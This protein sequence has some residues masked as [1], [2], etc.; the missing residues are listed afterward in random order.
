[1]GSNDLSGVIGRILKDIRIDLSDEFDKNFEREA[2]FSQAWARRK[3]PI[4]PGRKILVDTGQLRRSIQSRSSDKTITFFSSLPYADIHNEGGEIKVTRKMKGYFW[5]KYYEAT[6]SF[7]RKKN[8]ERRNDKRTVQLST[9]AEFW[10]FLALMREGK[11]IKIPKRQFIGASPE[12][13]RIVREIIEENLSE[14]FGN[15][16]TLK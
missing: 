4:R 9:E 3:S 11:S 5:H 14:Y 10:K 12:V 16:F 13:E 2:F 8:G 7:G 1:M 15:E 6:G